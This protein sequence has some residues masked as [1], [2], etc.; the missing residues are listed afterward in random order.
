MNKNFSNKYFGVLSLMVFLVI[1]FFLTVDLLKSIILTDRYNFNTSD[2]TIS[3][4]SLCHYLLFVIPENF[5][6]YWLIYQGFTGLRE[7]N[8]K[9]IVILN[10]ALIVFVFIFIGGIIKWAS[11]GFDH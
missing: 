9:R 2:P 10:I 11:T 5:I 1:S 3:R 4:K 8:R 7:S 6:F